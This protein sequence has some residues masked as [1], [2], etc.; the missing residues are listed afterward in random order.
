MS[1]QCE[2]RLVAER[3]GSCGHDA[4]F[5]LY[6]AS[7]G[8]FVKQRCMVCGKSD[9][10]GSVDAEKV[11]VQILCPECHSEM[12]V[13]GSTGSGNHRMECPRHPTVRLEFATLCDELEKFSLGD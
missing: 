10:V 6:R 11:A 12:R 1:G 3:R 7:S 5:I 9:L 4:P 2:L 13:V 8:G